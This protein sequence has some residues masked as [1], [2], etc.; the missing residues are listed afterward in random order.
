MP[1]TCHPSPTVCCSVPAAGRGGTHGCSA[2]WAARSPR[3]AVLGLSGGITRPESSYGEKSECVWEHPRP[4]QA[5]AVWKK[6]SGLG[7][8]LGQE[9]AAFPCKGGGGLQRGGSSKW[10]RVCKMGGL[11]SILHVSSSVPGRH[12]TQ[13]SPALRRYPGMGRVNL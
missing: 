6:Q 7:E 1:S 12:G 4:D 11:Q 8:R 2:S 9:A 5:R 10:G 13:Q 3:S